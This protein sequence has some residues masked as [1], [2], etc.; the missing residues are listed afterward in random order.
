ML[1]VS[2]AKMKIS[3]LIFP[4]KVVESCQRQKAV[5]GGIGISYQIIIN[6]PKTWQIL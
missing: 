3:G 4:P 6:V 2:C 5:V 1:A